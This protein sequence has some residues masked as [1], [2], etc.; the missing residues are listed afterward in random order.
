MK[1]TIKF[2]LVCCLVFFCS[3]S[4]AGCTYGGLFDNVNNSGGHTSETIPPTPGS[5]EE[6]TKPFEPTEPDLP[7]SGNGDKTME[8]LFYGFTYLSDVDSDYLFADS[9]ALDKKAF[10]DLVDRQINVFVQDLLIRLCTVYGAGL[11]T[12]ST[13]EDGTT[14]S[15]STNIKEYANTPDELINGQ[16]YTAPENVFENGV[17][18]SMNIA[19]V[20][21]QYVLDDLCE[22]NFPINHYSYKHM[23]SEDSCFNQTTTNPDIACV[24]CY[25][26]T[27]ISGKQPSSSSTPITT[28]PPPMSS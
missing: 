13:I 2:L 7:D 6:P 28:Y 1:N 17:E 10:R 20:N 9:S 24:G 27:L 5:T 8:D 26:Q 23:N 11:P 22:F 21:S 14:Y 15:L 19:A 16:D 25:A 12:E 4:F 3:F 18:H